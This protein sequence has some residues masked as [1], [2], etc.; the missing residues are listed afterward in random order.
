PQEHRKRHRQA[1]RHRGHPPGRQAGRLR[2]VRRYV[3]LAG[4]AQAHEAAMTR[5]TPVQRRP[6][7]AAGQGR[8]AQLGIVAASLLLAAAAWEL[9]GRRTSNAFLVP[10]SATL[11]R[12][13]E[14]ARR[15]EILRQA[16]DSLALFASGFGLAVLVGMPFGL[17]LA[18]VRSLRI[19][20]QDYIMI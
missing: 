5:V 1:G 17:L 7:A 20:V 13:W 12:L 3:G 11:V 14:M 6:R 9:L 4:G 10:L 2:D 18:R 19:A 16:G 8:W 15:G